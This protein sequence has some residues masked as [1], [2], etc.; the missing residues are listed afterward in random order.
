MHTLAPEKKK[1]FPRPLPPAP[2]SALVSAGALLFF[3]ALAFLPGTKAAAISITANYAGSSSVS[4]CVSPPQPT[5]TGNATHTGSATMTITAP[6]DVGSV[7]SVSYQNIGTANDS[8]A[9]EV[10]ASVADGYYGKL[11][12]RTTVNTSTGISY[13]P[14][15]SYQ[16]YY[17]NI[18]F[19]GV[20]Q[21]IDSG[22]ILGGADPGTYIGT[23]HISGSMSNFFQNGAGTFIDP[24]STNESMN[25]S[26]QDYQVVN[27]SAADAAS[28]GPNAISSSF[29]NSSSAG[30]SSVSSGAGVGASMTAP[31]PL[32][33]IA[34][35]KDAN[36]AFLGAG[37][38]PCGKTL[39]YPN[40]TGAAPTGSESYSSA[41]Y[42]TDL[43]RAG[44]TANQWNQ[45]GKASY[46]PA[47]F[48]GMRQPSYYNVDPALAGNLC[49]PSGSGPV[50]LSVQPLSCTAYQ[51]APTAVNMATFN[52][53][54]NS[55]RNGTS[56]AAMPISVTV[57]DTVGTVLPAYNFPTAAAINIG[58]A[59]I[60]GI[61]S[62]LQVLAAEVPVTFS[63]DSCSTSIPLITVGSPNTQPYSCTV[64]SSPANPLIGQAVTWSV[65]VE[66][67]GAPAPGT[68][69]YSWS[70][71]GGL[72]GTGPSAA[73]SYGAA[74]QQNAGVTVRTTTGTPQT[75]MCSNATVVSSPLSAT[76]SVSPN[77]VLT[78]T[79]VTW[80]AAPFGGSGNYSYLWSGAANGTAQ[81]VSGSSGA[82]PGTQTGTVTVTDASTGA[83]ASCTANLQ[84][85]AASTAAC[86]PIPASPVNAGASVSWLASLSPAPYDP[87]MSLSYSWSGDNGLTSLAAA[88][89]LTPSLTYNNPGTY[90]TS[91]QVTM[92]DKTTGLSQTSTGNCALTVNGGSS[93][94]FDYGLSNSGGIT[95]VA[96]Q[97][98]GNTIT[99]TLTSPPAQLLPL[100]V[101]GLPAGATA[102]LSP[103]SVTP[104]GTAALSIQ[105]SAATPIGTYTIAVSGG[106]SDPT[107]NDNTTTFLLTVN[108]APQFDYSL[109]NAGNLSLLAGEG[110]S[111]AVT[112]ALQSAPAQA[113]GLRVTN[114][115]FSGGGGVTGSGS[116]LSYAG[117]TV[118]VAPP[119]AGTPPFS[120]AVAVST[121]A[122]A[123]PGVYSVVVAGSASDP[124][125]FDNLTSFS[126]TVAAPPTL[127]YVYPLTCGA[128]RE[129][130]S[131]TSLR[132]AGATSYNLYVN[133]GS[134]P[135]NIPLSALTLVG[136][137]EYYY[138][139]SGTPGAMESYQVAGVNAS[140]AGGLSNTLYQVPP[141][142]CSCTATDQSGNPVGSV[143]VGQPVYW[144]AAPSGG[145]GSYNFSWS[146]AGTS[147]SANPTGPYTYAST[148]SQTA[149]VSITP[150]SAPANA[151]DAG[152]S[153]S[154][155][156]LLVFSALVPFDYHL[157]TPAAINLTAGQSGSSYVPV[158]LDQG[159][160]QTVSLSATGISYN[161]GAQT[162]AGNT[163]NGLT[164]TSFTPSSALPSFSSLVGVSTLSTTNP[165]T[166]VVTVDGQPKDSVTPA[167]DAT[168][169][170]VNVA[171]PS[172]Y[173]LLSAPGIALTA[174]GSGSVNLSAPLQSGT[175]PPVALSVSKIT[176]T[177]PFGNTTA[178]AGSSIN[179]LAVS[180]SPSSGTPTFSFVAN[181]TTTGGQTPT[182]AGTYAVTVTG[183]PAPKNGSA[184][185]PVT[186]SALP[187]PSVTGNAGACGGNIA[188]SYG[189]VAGATNYILARNPDA[190]NLPQWGD[191]ASAAAASAL[192]S[193]DTWLAPK[194]MY[195]YQL[196]AL[197]G[198]V[199]AY[200][201]I[202][203]VS[204]SDYCA[205]GAPQTPTVSTSCAGGGNATIYWS[206]LQPEV[207]NTVRGPAHHYDIFNANTGVSVLSSP[208]SAS[209]HPATYPNYSATIATGAS[210]THNEYLQAFGTS[211]LLL[212]SPKT[213]FSF[214]INCTPQVTCAVSPTSAV[215]PPSASATWTAAATGGQLPYAYSWSGSAPVAGQ[216]TSSV[217]ATYSAAGNYADSVT[218]TDANGVSAGPVSCG[219][220]TAT[221]GSPTGGPA[222]SGLPSPCNASSPTVYLS[223]TDNNGGSG[224]SGTNYTLARYPDANNL[225]QWGDIASANSIGSLPT[226][227][228]N[229]QWGT[230]YQYQ[231]RDKLSGSWLYSAVLTVAVPQ[232]CVVS[233]SYNLSLS[234]PGT[235][236]PG[237]NGSG[238]VTATLQS[239]T[240][241]PNVFYVPSLTSPGGVLYLGS[242]GF[243]S[244][245]SDHVTVSIPGYQTTPTWAGGVSSMTITTT[246]ATPPGNYTI[247]VNAGSP[248]PAN[249][250]QS[251]TVSVGSVGGSCYAKNALQNNPSQNLPVDLANPATQPVTWTAAASGG[252]PPYSYAWNGDW[253][254]LGAS[255]ASP[256][257]T[258][259]STGTKFGNVSICDSSSP[260]VCSYVSC[261]N[262]AVVTDSSANFAIVPAPADIYMYFIGPQ[263]VST[264]TNVTVLP[265][266]NFTSP[267]TIS[268]QTPKA[269]SV[270]LT[271]NFYNAGTNAVNAV[272]SQG[273]GI[274][275]YTSGLDMNVSATKVIPVGVYPLTIAGQATVGGV[276]VTRTQTVMLHV[277][278][279]KPNYTEF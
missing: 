111:T 14:Q 128:G 59:S 273:S 161:N 76:C 148:G 73:L 45:S 114:I 133:G 62:D 19:N 171:S 68:Y 213:Y 263:A 172:S 94:V 11:W 214:S 150:L 129:T 183:T 52:S 184:S 199:Y 173:S 266:M 166:Y 64:T 98:G 99:A 5:L 256:N 109:S 8:Y 102:T 175:M 49:G 162:A 158:T 140:G 195:Q 41:G 121:T 105:T 84:V 43:T 269:G 260:K 186:V 4:G 72:S 193:A 55:Y 30:N 259:S 10:G 97:S 80:T 93:S 47:Y 89:P 151:N 9:Y 165:G 164:V 51:Q 188:L 201:Q 92:T 279:T 235:I 117:V 244:D 56:G 7:Q 71:S 74:G 75:F 70:G 82:S 108:P 249:G 18:Q 15:C 135:L 113:I 155:P 38:A 87:N 35:L 61:D 232:S 147:G 152:L 163:L 276:P 167:N 216:T 243:V 176:Y 261:S 159:T 143:T 240:Q 134:V 224:P 115:S 78:N 225:P 142:A 127:T 190:N 138:G 170:T 177:D 160:S 36:G 139:Y 205:P 146:G 124:T 270:N 212:V 16:N 250:P 28:Y 236:T 265:T 120:N 222:V 65:A 234:C 268:G 6:G 126:V 230:N 264:K 247:S 179:G 209:P 198:G 39:Y 33:P 3:A 34:V 258:Y 168:T 81:S 42:Q 58:A 182:P 53:T 12:E 253:P 141:G 145:N 91:V 69:V 103:S 196:R 44:F 277:T 267:V 156:T 218:V 118:T 271:Y 46:T 106:V 223:Y 57:Y 180:L 211:S 96:G 220:F 119:A 246:S 252:T 123:A 88:G 86:A 254:L 26:A 95:V 207:V 37:P 203:Q 204:A 208:I 20:A 116:S 83:T 149:A 200:S 104:T 101:S 85:V 125:P 245:G 275:S 217:S 185:F 192:P 221:A 2:A 131:W 130:F 24:Y 77:P 29:A 278:N 231:L 157:S 215:V 136:S 255:G 132:S 31:A 239:G 60:P 90:H 22:A 23:A 54:L 191:I 1:N 27:S 238:S 228:G 206:V 251:C 122:A 257:V 50:Y 210:G 100:S 144:K 237:S 229:V 242:A 194:G 137:N 79:G 248:P 112:A 178:A 262:D 174:G 189:S 25:T 233:Y 227:D 169:L 197:V 274:G 67:N 110:G 21:T 154:C 219:A 40:P 187:T 153:L 13:P 17:G 32:Y 181:I 272:L 66:N 226:T 107:P 202:I 48:M 63:P 241:G